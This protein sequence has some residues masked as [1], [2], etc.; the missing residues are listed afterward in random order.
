VLALSGCLT[1]AANQVT[2]TTEHVEPE[3]VSVRHRVEPGQN[4]YRIAK[5][6]GLSPEDLA[7]ANGI[8]DARALAVGQELVIPGLG[9]VRPVALADPAEPPAD[10]GTKTAKPPSA[11]P[12]PVGSATGTLDWPL[13]GVLYG[14]FG[15]KGAEQHDGI[16]LAAPEGTPVKTAA[17]GTVLFAGEQKGYGQLVIVE[18][19]GGLVTLYAHNRDL[20]VKTGEKVRAEQVI[21]T[22]GES[23]RT[24]GPHL[25]FEVRKGGVPVDPMG[26]L[27]SAP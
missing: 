9:S 21:A 11:R 26:E 19:P 23:G 24:S 12:R 14:R 18:H 20:R 17:V 2:L 7:A 5:A 1:P 10:A 25:H 8:T 3:L 27:K 13:R 4:L 6:Y 15:K 16:D 22:V